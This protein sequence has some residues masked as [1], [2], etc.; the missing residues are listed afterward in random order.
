[1]VLMVK[2]IK[3]VEKLGCYACD[4][5]R[6]DGH[7]KVENRAAFWLPQHA[8]FPQIGCLTGRQGSG[9]PP[10]EACII[11]VYKRNIPPRE[12]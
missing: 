4:E 10:G 9:V 8:F 1:M 5:W 3:L 12:T 7:R 11:E 6:T 2:N